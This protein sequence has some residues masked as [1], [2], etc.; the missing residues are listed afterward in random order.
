MKDSFVF[1][2]SLIEGAYQNP[3]LSVFLRTYSKGNALCGEIF[4]DNVVDHGPQGFRDPFVFVVDK[5]FPDIYVH[6][7]D[8]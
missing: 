6:I 5:L 7:R 3:V 8:I 2:L 1:S 4:F